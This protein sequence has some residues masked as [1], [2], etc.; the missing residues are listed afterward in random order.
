VLVHGAWG[1]GWGF[2]E[3]DKMLTY[4]GYKVYRPTLTGL[5]ERVHQA[6]PDID[7]NLHIQDV[8]NVILW[9]GL[10]D[11]VLVGHSYGGM[12]ISG[13]IDRLPD[14]IRRAVYV[15]AMVPE[16]GEWVE[17]VV[18]PEHQ[19]GKRLPGA[20]VNGMNTPAWINPTKPPPRD[21][22]M[23]QKCFTAKIE[24]KN[25]EVARKV[26][27]KYILTVDPGKKPEDDLFYFCHLRAQQRGWKTEIMEGDHNPQW[28]QPK[29]LVRL[30]EEAAKER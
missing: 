25:Q 11:I 20:V 18:N 7:L 2:K 29:E 23:P 22:P 3:V 26:P 8:V 4:D 24:L 30:L 14:R 1:G 9:E 15:D 28:S 12:V 21:V 19:P 13:V 27:T 17:A 5:G 6:N 10:H 16:N